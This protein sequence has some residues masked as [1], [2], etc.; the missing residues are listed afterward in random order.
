[1]NKS[2]LSDVQENNKNK[3]N[4][5]VLSIYRTFVKYIKAFDSFEKCAVIQSLQNSRIDLIHPTNRKY[6]KRSYNYE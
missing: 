1:M 6:V 3:T 2:A 5:Q 4:K